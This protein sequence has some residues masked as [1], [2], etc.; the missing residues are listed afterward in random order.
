MTIKIPGS[1]WSINVLIPEN[2][3]NS[4]EIQFIHLNQVMD[5]FFLNSNQKLGWQKIE[6]MSDGRHGID[7]LYVKVVNDIVKDVMVAESKWNTSKVESMFCMFQ[8]SK[9]NQDISNWDTSNVKNM[10][11]MFGNSQFNQ[12]IS[13]WNT[14]KV[15]SM[16]YMFDSSQ[17]NQDISK[18]DTSNVISKKDMFNNSPKEIR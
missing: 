17:F 8:S 16:S 4:I 14:S 9:F 15:E 5:Y 13:K 11:N 1:I 3:H 12:D 7:G 6:G 18:W 2:S 10:E